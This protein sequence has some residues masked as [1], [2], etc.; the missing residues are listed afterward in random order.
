MKSHKQQI[1]SLK[2]APQTVS[3]ILGIVQIYVSQIAIFYAQW[4]F[5]RS[6]DTDEGLKEYFAPIIAGPTLTWLRIE[7]VGYYSYVLAI[8]A[9]IVWFQVIE[10]WRNQ[11]ITDIDKQINDFITYARVNM[12]WWGFSFMKIVIPMFLLVYTE[13]IHLE[14]STVIES[15]KGNISYLPLVGVCMI[16]STLQF[17]VTPRIFVADYKPYENKEILFDSEGK[18]MP[19]TSVF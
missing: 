15:R 3:R 13:I 6:E 17:V 10:F 19:I 14:D 8:S 9:Y 4:A 12:T 2:L 5:M 7:T 16:M 11:L 1:M 18:D